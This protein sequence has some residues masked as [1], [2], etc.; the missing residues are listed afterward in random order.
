M[1]TPRNE[2]RGLDAFNDQL[3]ANPQYR[4]FLQSIGVNPDRPVQLSGSQRAQAEQFV[5]R[6]YPDLAGKFQIDPAGNINTDHGVST[7]WSNPAFRYP[8]IAGG[9]ALTAGLINPALLGLGG[10]GGGSGAGGGVLASSSIP[11]LHAAVPG[12]IASQG[13]SAGIAAGAGGALAS[14]AIPGLHTAVPGAIA[15]H[16]A[17][18]G[19]PLGAMG[20]AGSAARGVGEGVASGISDKVKDFFTNPKSLAGLAGIIAALASRP[21]GSSADAAGLEDLKRLNGITEARMRRVDPLHQAVTQ[22]AYGRL[23]VSSRDGTQL[24]N[25]PLPPAAGGS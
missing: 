22:L 7:A 3:R 5:R 24:V 10:A 13:A 18:A 20:L 4:A 15:S 16:G 23:P 1:P 9:A 6:L 17:S 21:S 12:A 11:G 8:L 25:V 19:I 14:G 2:G